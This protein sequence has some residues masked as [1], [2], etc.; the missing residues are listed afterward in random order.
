M[1]E[2]SV[3]FGLRHKKSGKLLSINSYHNGDEAQFCNES[4]T[5]ELEE[6]NEDPWLVED[7]INVEYVRNFSTPWY[8]TNYN[9]PKHKYR[10]E[11]L[12]L[13]KLEIETELS[14]VSD[15][16]VPTARQ[17]L[18]SRYYKKDPKYLETILKQLDG[19]AEYTYTLYDLKEIKWNT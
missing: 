5:Y 3:K 14:V 15:V 7:S 4:T 9:S 10:S 2:K 8:N 17:Y 11:D 12:E 6:G 1:G 18:I 19:G 13:I 16:K